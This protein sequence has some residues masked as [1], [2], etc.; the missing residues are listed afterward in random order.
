MTKN[1]VLKLTIHR[2]TSLK[3]FAPTE[4]EFLI[5]NILLLELL[6]LGNRKPI[7]SEF[8]IIPF[9]FSLLLRPSTTSF[10]RQSSLSHL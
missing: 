8:I 3:N 6:A 5:Q 10:F 2:D 4:I 1:L 9:L 7:S